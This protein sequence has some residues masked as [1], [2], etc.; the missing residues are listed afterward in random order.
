[1]SWTDEIKLAVWA[2]GAI[3]EGY[4]PKKYRKDH[5][6]AWMQYG[7]YGDRGSDFGWEID[8]ITPESRGGTD[9]LSNLRPLQWENNNDKSNGN[10]SC[11]V[12]SKDAAN[13]KK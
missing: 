12:T 8:H 10:L 9:E 5:C 13:V 2:K 11:P 1:M 7:K 4:D 6:E 3:V